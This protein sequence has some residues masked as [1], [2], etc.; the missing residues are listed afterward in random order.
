VKESSPRIRIRRSSVVITSMLSIQAILL[1]SSLLIIAGM[2]ASVAW[3]AA[4]RRAPEVVPVE[5]RGERI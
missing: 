4:L 2:L 3:L 5:S 1:T